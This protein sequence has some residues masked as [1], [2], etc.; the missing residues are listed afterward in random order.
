M[1]FTKYELE[2]IF[3][4]RKVLIDHLHV[5]GADD[6]I[7]LFHGVHGCSSFTEGNKYASLAGMLL[8]LGFDVCLVE[9]SRI[10]RDRESFGDDR[11]EWA[12]QSF[13]GKKYCEELYDNC[14]ALS[15]ILENLEY[16]SLNL[17]G[18][19]LGGLHSILI[20]GYVWK[21]ILSACGA[22]IPQIDPE[23]IKTVITSG[24]GDSIKDEAR[25]SLSL[26]VLS[27]VPAAEILLRAAENIKKG[28]FLSFYGQMDATFSES[29]CRRIF[30]LLPLLPEDKSFHVI[31]GSDHSFRQMDGKP[32]LNPLEM[33]VSI[34]MEFKS[35]AIQ[36]ASRRNLE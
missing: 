14:K 31:P 7:V 20:K 19:S 5:K 18:F 27:T 12:W 29:S 30:E 22:S 3:G 25:N 34:L 23:R 2:G 11:T 9:T 4:D 21:E 10:R 17:W 33:T 8:P 6:L 26:P 15:F 36:G 13:K 24:S 16:P 32:S 1:D 28:R 35:T